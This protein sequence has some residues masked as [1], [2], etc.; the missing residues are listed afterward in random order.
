VTWS[1]T[2][3]ERRLV[4]ILD[5]IALLPKLRSDPGRNSLG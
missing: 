3:G 4:E 5:R 2:S 1:V